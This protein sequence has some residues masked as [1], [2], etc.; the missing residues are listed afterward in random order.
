MTINNVRKDAPNTVES[1][2]AAVRGG[3][4][5][6]SLSTSDVAKTLPGSAAKKSHSL[7]CGCIGKGDCG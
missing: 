1:L 6:P 2:I 5:T 3:E 4:L 7:D